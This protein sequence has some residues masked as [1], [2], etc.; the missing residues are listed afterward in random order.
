MAM[1]IAILPDADRGMPRWGVAPS[2]GQ[3]ARI[4]IGAPLAVAQPQ[5]RQRH[6]ET[7]GVHT[8]TGFP[9]TSTPT[10]D[11]HPRIGIGNVENRLRIMA[12]RS[13]ID[14]LRDG[15]RTHRR[16]RGFPA[17][18]R[19]PVVPSTWRRRLL[20]ASFRSRRSCGP[21]PRGIE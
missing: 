2:H 8:G 4:G 20:S 17:G 13:K 15:G 19:R 1:Y 12:A 16:R 18:S 9:C 14:R 3:A 5:T 6:A 21:S 10:W 11:V 7:G